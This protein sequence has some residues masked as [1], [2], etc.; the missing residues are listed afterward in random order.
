MDNDS[1]IDNSNDVADTFSDFFSNAVKNLC[2]ENVSKFN[3][4]EIIHNISDPIL[5][6]IK[7][8]ENHPSILKIQ[9]A[10]K[11]EEIFEFTY[12]TPDIVSKE[13]NS[14]KDATSCPKDSI[15]SN[16]IK[17]NT[18]IFSLKLSHDFNF[19]IDECI[20]PSNLK[21]ADVT[22]AHK[23]G[24]RTDKTNYRR[25]SVLQAMSKILDRL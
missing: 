4:E 1:I 13:I 7:R 8:F 3:N 5:K 15:P 12:I 9:E 17:C 6:A 25:V 21:R 22:P 10:M 14:L 16:I 18:D 2:I 19:S 24:D 20:F 23:K 11:D